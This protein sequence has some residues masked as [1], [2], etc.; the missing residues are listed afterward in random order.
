[1]EGRAK[2]GC[3]CGGIVALVSIILLASSF[4]VLDVNEAGIKYNTVSVQIDTTKIYTSGRFYVGLGFSFKIFN[5]TRHNIEF[6]TSR[7]KS[8]PPL[9]ITLGSGGKVVIDCSFQ[10]SLK[11]G[12]LQ[13]LYKKY[14]TAY[15]DKFIKIG[16]EAIKG[17]ARPIALTD[18]Y[19][20]RVYVQNTVLASLQQ[21]FRNDFVTV[22]DFQLRKVTL[23]VQTNNQVLST[24]VTMEQGK[25]AKKIQD[26]KQI[27]AESL[28]ITANADAVIKTI[29]A[30][31]TSLSTIIENQATAVATSTRLGAEGSAFQSIKQGLGLSSQELLK[32]IWVNNLKYSAPDAEIVASFNTLLL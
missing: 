5:L 19:L 31:T 13:A 22:H 3:F 16:Q 11:V 27:Q 28:V 4:A 9:D 12:E 1:M 32:Y 24:L 17:A 15:K 14:G 18:F 2:C 7:S 10:Y 23:P 21:A 30:N 26:E 8:G 25:T 20:R 29:V 6:S